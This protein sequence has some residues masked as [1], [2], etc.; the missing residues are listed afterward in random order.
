MVI[1]CIALTSS[2]IPKE[3]RLLI[4]LV[5]FWDSL[6]L[7][8]FV[9]TSGFIL[10]HCQGT[11]LLPIFWWCHH[12]VPG[13]KWDVYSAFW[14]IEGDLFQ[15]GVLIWEEGLISG[16]YVLWSHSTFHMNPQTECHPCWLETREHSFWRRWSGVFATNCKKFDLT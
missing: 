6:E 14:Q 3:V 5:F 13:W 15:K 4:G 8:S 7:Y 9:P 12:V 16:F 2:W 11:L 10:F 1:C